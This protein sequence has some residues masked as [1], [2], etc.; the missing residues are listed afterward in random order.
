[1]K[2]KLLTASILILSSN[3]YARGVVSGDVMG[4]DML[5]KEI[6][7]AARIGHLALAT[8]DNIFQTTDVTIEMEPNGDNSIVWGSVKGFKSKARYWGSRSGLITNSK[9]MYLALHA[10]KLQ[11]FWCPEYTA[12][13]YW[14]IG[15]GWFDEVQ[16][17]HPTVCGKFRC[18]VF[19]GYVMGVGGATQ[20][21]NNRIQLPY[22]AFMTF[23]V[24]NGSFA[25]EKAMPNETAEDP[26]RATKFLEVTVDDLNKMTLEEFSVFGSFDPA[27]TPEKIVEK[28]WELLANPNVKDYIKWVLI[29]LRSMSKVEDTPQKFIEIFEKSTSAFVKTRIA[30]GIMGFY[31]SN[32]D[33]IQSNSNFENIKGFFTKAVT[34]EKPEHEMSSYLIRGFIDFH[35][36]SEIDRNLN[37]IEKHLATVTNKS[38]IGLQFELI[39]KSPELQNKFLPASI[40]VLR[41]ANDTELDSKFFYYLNHGVKIIEDK[42]LRKDIRDFISEKNTAY[43][44]K[45]FSGDKGL[46]EFH[47]NGA[48]KDMDELM[49]KLK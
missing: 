37:L 41:K 9:L 46:A 5:I 7:G 31:Q 14:R 16:R 34:H 19:V 48:R 28:Q 32:W 20:I 10:A 42:T 13:T 40:S 29:D 12:T 3:I 6:P 21:L 18:D 38:L 23:P 47:A 43:A 45:A 15:D 2:L 11:S 49:L 36:A 27:I 8:G 44:N 33:E 39:R 25:A 17:P 30:S 1:M 35:D 24:D 26:D 4:R 22:N